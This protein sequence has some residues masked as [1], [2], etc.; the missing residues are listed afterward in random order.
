MTKRSAALSAVLFLLAGKLPA[1]VVYTENSAA[2][3]G[4]GAHSATYVSSSAVTLDYYGRAAGLAAPSAEAWYNGGWQYRLALSVNSANASTLLS[5]PV[6][7]TLNTQALITAGRLNADGSDIRFTTAAAAGAPAALPYYIE[8]G[9]NTASTKIWVNHP[10]VAAGTNNLYMYYGNAAAAAASSMPGTF[11]LGDNFTGADG[12]A[13]SSSTWVSIESAAPAAGSS[14]TLLS[15]RLRLLFGSPL[16]TRYYGLRSAGQYSFA[17][18]RQYRAD[19]GARTG[20]DSWS[21]LTL[22]QSVYTY[23]YDQDDWLRIAVHHTPSGAAYSLERSDAGIKTVLAAGGLADGM[24]GVRL[25]IDASSVTVLLDGAQIYSAANTLAF[26]SPYLYL[27]AASAA[28]SLEEF[29]FDNVSVQPYSAPEPAFGA[30]GA[31]QGRRYPSG[32]FLSQVKDTGSTSRF[33]YADWLDSSPS[34]SSVTLQ[35]RASDTDVNLSTFAPVTK[36]GDPGVS[37][38][39]VQ[40]RLDFASAD[41]RYA[42]SVSSVT[43]MYGSAPLAPT[44][45]AG[46]ALSESSVKWTWTDASSGQYQEDGYRLFDASGAL[47]GSAPQ[48]AAE[49]TETG[50]YANTQYTRAV[51]GYN[52]AGTGASAAATR[53]TLALPPNVSCDHSTGTWLSGSLTC[54]NLAGFGPNGVAYYRYEWSQQPVK[55]WSGAEAQWTGGTLSKSDFSTGN[56]YLHVK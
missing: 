4:A 37:G 39:Y 41:P 32:Y 30:A 38:R 46:A 44:G 2:Q 50:L 56:Y 45:A 55:T 31:E 18:G 13:P 29:L 5:Y 20:T 40:Y 8:S 10:S 11:L 14:R 47:T 19:L 36:G 16:N 42:A 12:T 35:M 7:V 24:H 28:S 15:G 3:F 53:Y 1:Q 9:L 54:I 26:N 48:N 27:E 23:S 22:C 49:W 21:S 52:A 33:T 51:A 34:G 43:E 25:F 17:S 6:A